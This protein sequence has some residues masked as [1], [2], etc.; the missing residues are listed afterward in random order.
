MLYLYS[1]LQNS[2]QESRTVYEIDFSYELQ[3]QKL[4]DSYVLNELFV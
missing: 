4:L 1:L 2:G 3:E